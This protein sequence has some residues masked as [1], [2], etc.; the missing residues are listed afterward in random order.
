MLD[1]VLFTATITPMSAA[2][3]PASRTEIRRDRLIEAAQTVF[4]REGLRGASMERIAAEA[5]VA[6][7]TVYAYFTDKEDAFVQVAERLAQMLVDTVTQALAGEGS[8]GER[9]R[10]AIVAKKT[11]AY[12]VARQSPYAGDLLAA[13]DRLAGPVFAAADAHILAAVRAA[14]GE[15]GIDDPAAATLLSA[16]AGVFHEAPDLATLQLRLTLLVDAMLKGLSG[17]D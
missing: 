15:L 3:Q 8:A 6:R 12:E 5:G 9:I 17:V 13:K 10:G 11:L 1:A 7:A 16:S 4:A 14:L 2:A